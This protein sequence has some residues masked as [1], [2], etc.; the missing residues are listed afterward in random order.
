[1]AALSRESRKKARKRGRDGEDTDPEVRTRASDA[2]GDRLA[3]T[4]RAAESRRSKRRERPELAERDSRP[5]DPTDPRGIADTRACRAA[6][7]S[8]LAG[9][10]VPEGPPGPVPEGA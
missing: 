8:C 2:L 1:M 3:L 6:D 4:P 7:R 9:D 10:A 5:L